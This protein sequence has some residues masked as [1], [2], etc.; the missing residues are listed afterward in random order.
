MTALELANPFGAPVY[1]EETVS[2]T[3]D[4]S[5]IL[6]NRGEPGGTVIT[7]DFQES[8]RGRGRNRSW[9]MDRGKNLSFT[10]L[11]RFPGFSSIPRALTLRTGLA[12]SLGIEDFAPALLGAVE[13]KWPNDIMIR[14]YKAQ[15]ACK[16]AGILT[17]AEGA[18]VYIG[19]GVNLGQRE[20]PPEYRNKAGSII[21]ALE[22]M[23]LPQ[24]DFEEDARFRLLEAIL[25]RLHNEIAGAPADWKERLE[26]RLYKRGETVRFIEGSPE[27]EKTVDGLLAG[28]GPAGELLIIPQ[29]ETAPQPYVT[30][31]LRIYSQAGPIL[32]PLGRF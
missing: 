24:G 17:E 13:V 4:V 10:V 27:S 7:A 16:A 21:L 18:L 2:S 23:G 15:T 26:R 32:H 25:L 28:I 1:Y 8:G 9:N 30:G 20:F 19:I 3:M 29:G 11:L 22:D 31:E 12:V 6:S 5:R 14:S